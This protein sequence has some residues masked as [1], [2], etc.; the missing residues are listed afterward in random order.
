L[1]ELWFPETMQR[2]GG[3]RTDWL[4]Y[5]LWMGILPKLGPVELDELSKDAPNHPARLDLYLQAGHE[6]YM[7]G[8]EERAQ[9]A[10]QGILDG[11]IGYVARHR[12]VQSPISALGAI[13][14]PE[15]YGSA[16]LGYSGIPYG[17]LWSRQ[18]LS[19]RPLRDLSKIAATDSIAVRE[20]RQL[21]A[22]FVRVVG[23]PVQVW[24]TQLGPWEELIESGRRMWGERW[25]SVRL[26]AISAGIQS[27]SE[28]YPEYSELFDETQP[29]CR[30]T[31]YARL[32]AGAPVWWS[33]QAEG[34]E[35][36][37][38]GMLLTT[39]LLLWSG[40]RTFVH[41]SEAV[42]STI[43][44]MSEVDYGKV[45]DFVDHS[46][47]PLNRSRDRRFALEPTLFPSGLSP[48]AVAA[49]MLRLK[50]QH[51]IDF[52]LSHLADYVGNDLRVLS[53]CQRAEIG[54]VKRE[55]DRWWRLADV[56][57]KAYERV[58]LASPISGPVVYGRDDIGVMPLGVAKQIVSDA[59]R[60]P[61]NLVVLAESRCR[62]ALGESIV[63]VST[64]AA[65]DGWFS[66]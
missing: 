25:A 43:D 13:L 29:L 65:R 45:F 63:P 53:M 52:Y 38:E 51:R 36:S 24:R 22:I 9:M 46:M 10:L 64:V 31:R 1:Y 23:L 57:K 32:R 5:G 58:G 16:F 60:Y 44:K 7:E 19:V 2:T 40:E 37:L 66:S 17:N 49:F 4:R 59:S 41:L 8:D 34:A 15:P 42:S 61:Y 54:L 21:L 18:A 27:Q 47:W 20:A 50:P 33:K 48:R 28:T 55:R 35:D 62:Q 12:G 3:R 11:D 39:L 30:R 56:A 14:D 6:S 26:A